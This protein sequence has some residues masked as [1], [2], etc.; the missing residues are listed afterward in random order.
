MPA[1]I[2][3]WPDLVRHRKYAEKNI[4]ADKFPAG[5]NLTETA[6]KIEEHDG[7]E[8]A[9]GYLLAKDKMHLASI[10]VWPMVAKGFAEVWRPK[11]YPSY[12]EYANGEMIP[13]NGP[14]SNSAWNHPRWVPPPWE[15]SDLY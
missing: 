11:D 10:R 5:A 2:V 6:E 14:L 3:Y 8:E 15:V 7:S 4:P 9:I 12:S 1:T 13:F